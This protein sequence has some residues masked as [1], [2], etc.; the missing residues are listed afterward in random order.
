MKLNPLWAVLLLSAGANAQPANDDCS[1]ALPVATTAFGLT[2]T[3]STA[4]TTVNA[5]ASLPVPACASTAADDDIWYSFTPATGSILI[6]ISNALLVPAG[7]ASIGF[8]VLSGSCGNL[9]GVFCNGNVA[10]GNGQQIVTGLSGG[11]TYYLRFWT[12]STT[13]DANFSFCVQD[14]PAPPANDECANAIPITTQPFGTA[15]TAGLAATT[16]GATRSTPDAPCSPN[17]AN[18][19]IWYSFTAQSTSV[20]LRLTNGVNPITNSGASLSYAL[21]AACPST[22]TALSCETGIAF[23]N[24]Y[25]IIDGLTAGQTYYLRLYSQ[26]GNNYLTFNFC[27]QDVP[28]AP[29]NDA[30]ANAIAI[31]TQP[32]GSACAASVSANTS[33]AT[34]SMPDPNCGANDAN[35]D[36]WYSFTAQ[37]QS[38]MLRFANG[39]NVLTG[40]GASLNYALYT[41]CPTT[42]ASLSCNVGIGFG[43]G[44]T[45]IDEL[46]VGQT[47]YLRLFSQ[48]SNNYMSFTFCVQDVP[49]APANDACASA[50]A[51]VPQPFGT[52]CTASVSVNTTGATRSVPDAPCGPNDA[53]DD[54]WYNF[55]ATSSSVILRFSNGQFTTSSGSISVGYALYAGNCPTSTAALSCS[56]GIG[57]G[58]GYQIIDG[59]AIGQTYYLR[60][61]TQGTHNYATFDFCLQE[62]PPP[63]VNDDCSTAIAIAVQPFGPACAASVS[64]NTSGAT[65]SAPDIPCGANDANDDIW[66]SFTATSQ[67]AILRFGNGTSTTIG[68]GAALGF[69]L[70]A[71]CPSTTA[72]FSCEGSIGFINGHRILTGLAI[73]QT[74]YLRLFAQ[75]SNN[76][77]GFTFCVQE[78]PPPPANDDCSGAIPVTLTLP[79]TLCTGTVQVNT[80]GAT[81]SVNNPTCASV[82]SNDDLWYSFTA[83]AT[84]AILRFTNCTLTTDGGSGGLGYALYNACPTGTASLACNT[85]IGVVNGSV[86]LTGLVAGN[87]YYLRLFA[88]GSNNYASFLFCIQAPLANDECVNAVNIPVSNGFCNTAV[89]SSLNGATTSAGFGPP[90]CV[91]TAQSKEVWFKVTVPAT[92]NLLVQTSPV[93]FAANNLAMVAYTGTCGSLT[94]LACDDNG[95][96]DPAPA[97][98]HSRLS[99]TGRTPGEVI[100]L[101]VIPLSNANEEQFAICAWDETPSVLPPIAASGNCSAGIAP[102]IDSAQGNIYR[103][104]PLYNNNGEIIAEIYANGT[105]LGNTAVQLYVNNGPVRNTNDTFYLDRNVTISPAQPG[106]GWVRLYLQPAELAALQTVD[107]TVSPLANLLAI[108]AGNTCV[109][110]FGLSPQDLLSSKGSYGSGYYIQAFTSAWGSFYLMGKCGTSVTWTGA[111][112]TAWNNPANWSCEG[113]PHKKSTAIIPAGMPRYPVVAASTTVK[114][115]DVQTGASVTVLGG[116][117]LKIGAN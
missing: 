29:V 66:Y 95:N 114:R 26:G 28:A 74:Y 37:S 60:L 72:A 43:N 73:G 42:T 58:N 41:A 86:N 70:Y 24:G 39:V 87:T 23:G 110:G 81:Q 36:I 40:S 34:R 115:L 54:V 19:D 7:T 117:G 108:R 18:D 11:T 111:V 9:T 103:W 76:Y 82:N 30:C 88:S 52:A 113:V 100:T 61:F 50:I 67:S 75:G 53:N 45:I 102:T 35:D 69:A 33:G 25:K 64:A 77:M 13:N 107:S 38:I 105:S 90:P 8:E 17:D 20:L 14:V 49:A 5:T 48:G 21:Y 83:T 96:P 63:P 62:V 65:R 31:T 94:Q 44:L 116:V 68:S 78:V 89:L 12:P 109:P 27:V 85:N 55:T 10:F 22:T 92:G 71:S 91:A 32:F 16:V 79:G 104:V 47:Y 57:F 56:V 97:D 3:A 15:C 4:A 99:F 2:C 6:R 51:I 59:L 80:S 84:L 101:R 1:G 106:S 93:K 98:N 46:T 112:D